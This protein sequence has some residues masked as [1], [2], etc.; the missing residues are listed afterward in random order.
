[1]LLPRVSRKRTPQQA[2]GS[3]KRMRQLA[4]W[5]FLREGFIPTLKVDV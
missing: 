5:I 2:E 1:M 3:K 4:S